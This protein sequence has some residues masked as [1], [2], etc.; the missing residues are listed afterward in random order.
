MLQSKN[1]EIINEKIM[2]SKI[3]LFNLYKE[4]MKLHSLSNTMNIWKENTNSVHIK[5]IGIVFII[6]LVLYLFGVF[7]IQFYKFYSIIFLW[8]VFIVI[9]IAIFVK[10]REGAEKY[11]TD[12]IKIRNSQFCDILKKYNIDV[13]NI[14]SV[15]SYFT[16]NIEPINN[17]VYAKSTIINSIFRFTVNLFYLIVGIIMPKVISELF[18]I[19]KAQ[20][21]YI[22]FSILI[23][24]VISMMIMYVYIYFF[25]NRNKH[26][27]ILQKMILELKMIKILNK[28]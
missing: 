17:K 1:N 21:Y 9:T 14:D 22:I 6:D 2:K 23:L 3:E 15:I 24:I 19:D 4:Y 13:S 8:M 16:L 28:L 11:L 26:L 5:R 12:R 18:S 27:D 20:A 25:N 7:L 10:N